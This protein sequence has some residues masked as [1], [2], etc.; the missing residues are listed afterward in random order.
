[1]KERSFKL[2][3]C[4]D[5]AETVMIMSIGRKSYVY[6]FGSGQLVNVDSMYPDIV[7]LS[8]T[9]SAHLHIVETVVIAFWKLA[10]EA[11]SNEQTSSESSTPSVPMK[12]EDEPRSTSQIVIASSSGLSYWTWFSLT[13]FEDG[14]FFDTCWQGLHEYLLHIYINT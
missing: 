8:G 6:H 1:M 9:W 2:E 3:E 12:T 10:V 14:K 7:F 13:C 11:I 5:L 4:R